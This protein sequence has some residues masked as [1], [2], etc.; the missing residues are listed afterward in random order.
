MFMRIPVFVRN[1]P[2]WAAFLAGV[3]AAGFSMPL[4]RFFAVVCLVLTLAGRAREPRPRFRLTAP[5]VG[6]LG[7]FALA[8]VVSSIMALLDPD[9]LLIP[10][11]GLGK[12]FKL[13][14]FFL[15]PLG[16]VQIRS[17]ERF[18]QALLTL[19]LGCAAIAAYVV[20]VNP[21]AAWIQVTLPADAAASV[22]RDRLLA[23]TDALGRT[24]ALMAWIHKGYRAMTYR[25]SLFKLGTMGDAQ[26]LM[27]ALPV[28]LCLTLEAFRNGSGPRRRFLMAGVT[29]LVLAG[30]ML[31][32]KRGPLLFGGLVAVG[33]LVRMTGLK[34]L[35]AALLVVS[36]AAAH[37]G[38]RMRFMA[39]PDELCV[40]R[41][42]RWTMWVKIVPALHAEH[43]WGIGFRAL[44]N[45]KMRQHA[46]RVEQRQNH[47]HSTPLQALVDFGWPGVAAYAAWMIAALWTALGSLRKSTSTSPLRFAPLAMLVALVLYGLME[48]NLADADVVLLY[49]LAMAMASFIH[50]DS[51]S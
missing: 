50:A 2:S 46:P 1:D 14:W 27:V 51:G 25:D 48:Y 49:S 34:G 8:L 16:V 5:C 30:L 19:V 11:N 12:I 21:L 18:F 41:G 43:P 9:P 7:Y 33:I 36:L 3:F 31:T 15:I 38:V 26:R 32:F 22:A 45:E 10:R 35:A 17:H 24:D 4:S 47:V 39:L 40:E 29:L 42:G 28:A 44:T 23:L 13:A 37:P 6:W 20:L